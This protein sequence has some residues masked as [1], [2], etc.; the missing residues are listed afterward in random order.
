MSPLSLR[1]AAGFVGAE[2]LFLL[3]IAVLGVIH[4]SNLGVAMGLAVVYVISAL[5]LAVAGVGLWERRSWGRAPVV[6]AQLVLLGVAWD[7]HRDQT[8]VAI[9]GAALALAVLGCVLH[10]A[11]TRALSE[12][13]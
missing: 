10:P 4:P 9:A 8:A 13:S 3:V 12:H 11:S 2:C 7:V 5:G 1:L 6:L